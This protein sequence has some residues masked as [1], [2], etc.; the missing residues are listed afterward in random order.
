LF[1]LREAQRVYAGKLITDDH[2]MYVVEDGD[3]IRHTD[4]VLRALSVCHAERQRILSVIL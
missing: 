2:G 3:G 4:T 1:C